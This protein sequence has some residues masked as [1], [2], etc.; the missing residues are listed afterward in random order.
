MTLLT[1]L[2]Q[3]LYLYRTSVAIHPRNGELKVK[4]F[5]C[6][7]QYYANVFKDERCITKNNVS[8]P[9]RVLLH[10]G[11]RGSSAASSKFR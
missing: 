5:P 1:T 11:Q 10:R 9:E 4:K 8:A 6:F 7:T 2:T 3:H